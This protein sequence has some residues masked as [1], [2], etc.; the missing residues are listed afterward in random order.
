MEINC[1]LLFII[2]EIKETISYRDKNTENVL[3]LILS[4]LAGNLQTGIKMA[5]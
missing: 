3:S 2:N 1:Q 4:V 5:P